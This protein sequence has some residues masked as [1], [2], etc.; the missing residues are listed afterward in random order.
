MLIETSSMQPC[1]RIASGRRSKGWLHAFAWLCVVGC[2]GARSTA[3]APVDRMPTAA[4]AKPA[5]ADR[6]GVYRGGEARFYLDASG[7]GGGLTPD[8]AS[9]AFGYG[10]DVP[11]VGR[12]SNPAFD[13]IGVFR[14]DEAK[15]YLDAN[16]NGRW[17]ADDII[18][19]PFGSSGDIPIVGDWDGDGRDNIAVFRPSEATFY[20]DQNATGAWDSGDVVLGAF[21]DNADLPI[22]GDWNGDGRDE[23]GTYR[24]TER[25]FYLDYNGDGAWDS[26]HDRVVGPF[27]WD[28][29]LP[30][31]G[32]WNGNGVDT[33]GVY[34][35][36]TRSFYLDDGDGQ[37]TAK[38]DIERAA[39]GE[40]GDRPLTGH[41]AWR[42][43]VDADQPHQTIRG[44]G[45]SDA[46]N[47][48]FVGTY[49]ADSEKEAIARLLFDRSVD[50]EGDPKGIG[51][52][53]WRFNIGAGS[54]EQGSTSGIADETR[55]SECFLSADGSYDFSRQQGQQWFLG[56]A[57]DYGVERLVA[58]SVS[59]PVHYTRSLRAN[60]APPAEFGHGT[61]SDGVYRITSEASGKV[62]DPWGDGSAG[63]RVVQWDYWGGA[64]QHWRLYHLGDHRFTVENANSGACLTSEGAAS[65][66]GVVLR[67]QPC[68]GRASQRWL[69]RPEA[70]ENYALVADENH[71]VASV[72]DYSTANGAELLQWIDVGQANQRFQFSRVG[73]V[74][75][76]NIRSG[77][78]ADFARFLATVLGNFAA[79]GITF[80]LIS[81]LNEPQYPWYDSGLHEGSPWRNV[82]IADLVAKLDAEIQ[83]RSLKTKIMVGEAGKYTYLYGNEPA[84]VSSN[85]VEAFFDPHSASYLGVYP[86]VAQIISG[87]GYF[88]LQDNAMITDVR[89]TMQKKAARYGLE[90]YQSEWSL[91]DL[92]RIKDDQPVLQNNNVPLFRTDIALFLAKVVYSDFALADVSSWSFW[93][94]LDRN[95][96]GHENRFLLIETLPPDGPGGSMRNSGTHIAHKT[97]WTLGNYSRFVRPGYRR[98]ELTGARDLSGLMATAFIAPDRSQLVLVYVNLHHEDVVVNHTLRGIGQVGKIVP[99]LTNAT[100]DL[101]RQAEVT[102]TQYSLP[103]RSVVTLVVDVQQ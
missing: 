45:A 82:E 77:R 79:Q 42:V 95:R 68:D 49:W 73:A 24:P 89:T 7:R 72:A 88:T 91:I 47:T 57:I 10:D 102:G 9:E 71:L 19:G 12:W 20:L 66:Q 34:R 83:D 5:V 39:Y 41:W 13:A 17:D 80:D 92:D 75:H 44:I 54:A 8:L 1:G 22:V 33:V 58:F 26:E 103:A 16:G 61:F 21:G 25:R 30:L 6:V 56:Q 101:K 55:R 59:P 62:V 93:T 53:M 29:D 50:D 52:S 64:K 27:G 2:R 43:V 97:L 38:R 99:Y 87:H 46:W 35:P 74:P 31:A 90:T 23:V 14:P 76:A 32:D 85:Q 78:Q 81:P 94:A 18:L 69:L 70:S 67:M 37:W 60:V 63:Q 15:F 11:I 98:V 40:V 84:A 100:H 36:A 48:N 86:S 3:G 65:A 28:S 4:T 51:L 96:W